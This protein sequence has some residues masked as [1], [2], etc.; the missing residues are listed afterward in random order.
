MKQ[1]DPLHWFG[2]MFI[3]E[4]LISA[5]KNFRQALEIVTQLANIVIKM[6]QIEEL[7]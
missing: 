6:R 4:H 1:S 3:S 5:Q 7:Q 2:V